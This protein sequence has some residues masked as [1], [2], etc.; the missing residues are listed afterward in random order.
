VTEQSP[1][2]PPLSPASA[3]PGAQPAAATSGAEFQ[4]TGS[5]D[6]LTER[7]EVKVAATFAGG[8]IV[9]TILKRFAR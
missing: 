4:S 3:L 1:P 5:G 7:P 8:L 9:A 6:G 2:E